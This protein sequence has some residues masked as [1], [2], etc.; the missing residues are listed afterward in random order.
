MSN[1]FTK[2]PNEFGMTYWQHARFALDFS[3]H[4]FAGVL[5]SVIHALLPF[6]FKTSTSD[7]IKKMY[8]KIAER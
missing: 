5:T 4:L 8:G 2:H 6:L 3:V 1:P 7:I